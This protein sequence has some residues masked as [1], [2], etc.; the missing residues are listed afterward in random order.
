MDLYKRLK[1][2]LITEYQY[3][4]LRYQCQKIINNPMLRGDFILPLLISTFIFEVLCDTNV[5]STVLHGQSIVLA[6]N[7]KRQQT[8]SSLGY[9]CA[10]ITLG[11]IFFF[12]IKIILK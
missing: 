4:S 9:Q 11:E 5:I 2:M 10:L 8:D 7:L 1:S 6:P 12:A 3:A